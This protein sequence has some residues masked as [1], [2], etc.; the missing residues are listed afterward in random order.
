MT[1]TKTCSCKSCGPNCKCQAQ[2]PKA[3]ECCCGPNCT[4]GPSCQCPTSCGCGSKA[5]R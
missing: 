2:P 4:C 3:G 1:E 5:E